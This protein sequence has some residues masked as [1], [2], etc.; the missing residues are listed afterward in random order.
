MEQVEGKS[1]PSLWL[2]LT[3]DEVKD[4]MT[5]ICRYGEDL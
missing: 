3:A 2:S 5:Q 4:I 1:L